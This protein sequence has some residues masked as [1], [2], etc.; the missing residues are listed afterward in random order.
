MT[1]RQ[2]ALKSRQSSAAAEAHLPVQKMEGSAADW[3]H[4]P[5]NNMLA[6]VVGGDLARRRPNGPRRGDDHLTNAM[7]G[8]APPLP[9]PVVLRPVRASMPERVDSAILV[10]GWRAA[11]PHAGRADQVVTELA[12]EAGRCSSIR[13]S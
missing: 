4:R 7:E 6:V 3:R 13:T 2:P 9:P 5:T 11:G 10:G 12:D 8:D 1:R